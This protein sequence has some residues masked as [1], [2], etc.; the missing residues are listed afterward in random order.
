MVANRDD[1][2]KISALTSKVDQLDGSLSLT[3]T[4]ADGQQKI[5]WSKQVLLDSALSIVNSP[6]HTAIEATLLVSLVTICFLV[7]SQCR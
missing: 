5:I 3:F 6:S 4:N 2:A 1:N 7:V